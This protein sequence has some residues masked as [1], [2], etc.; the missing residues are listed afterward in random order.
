MQRERPLGRRASRAPGH[1]TSL[2]NSLHS[3]T[4]SWPIGADTAVLARQVIAARF[5]VDRFVARLNIEHLRAALAENPDAAR[6]QILERLLAEEEAK[7]KVLDAVP[8]LPGEARRR[9]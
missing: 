5:S 8:Q 6:R 9:V 7:L 1:G 2:S 3:G 4:G